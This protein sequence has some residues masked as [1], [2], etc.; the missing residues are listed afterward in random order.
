MLACT[1]ELVV[2]EQLRRLEEILWSRRQPL[3]NP[4]PAEPLG[5]EAAA[6]LLVTFLD[7]GEEQQFLIDVQLHF[8]AHALYDEQL[9]GQVSSYHGRLREDCMKVL[10][11]AGVPDPRSRQSPWTSRL[12]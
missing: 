2:D 9:G 1:Y 11:E 8:L 3:F 7:L 5:P 4:T 6:E 10:R 12:C